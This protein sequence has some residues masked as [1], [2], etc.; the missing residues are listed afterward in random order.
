MHSVNPFS[1]V[2]MGLQQISNV[3]SAL[4]V[5]V[6]FLLLRYT[7]CIASLRMTIQM[8]TLNLITPL[9]VILITNSFTCFQQV[10]KSVD[11]TSY[12]RTRHDGIVKCVNGTLYEFPIVYFIL[13]KVTKGPADTISLSL[14]HILSDLRNALMCFYYLPLIHWPV[15]S[16]PHNI[17]SEESS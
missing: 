15:I 8:E 6:T 5:L 4:E 3:P 17:R 16:Y 1:S 2:L 11:C 9:H 10:H 12:C 7:C 13:Y 14:W